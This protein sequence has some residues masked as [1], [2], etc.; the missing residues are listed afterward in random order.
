MSN[1]KLSDRKLSDRKLSDN[2][3]TANS[4]YIT[5]YNSCKRLVSPTSATTVPLCNKHRCSKRI[6]AFKGEVK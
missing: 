5:P 2:T 1:R 6:Y 3:F 4:V